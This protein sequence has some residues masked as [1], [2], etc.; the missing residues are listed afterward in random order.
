MN[1]TIKR[2]LNNQQQQMTTTAA[3]VVVSDPELFPS[4]NTKQS[5]F[6]YYSSSKEEEKVVHKYIPVTTPVV[7]G[8]SIERGQRAAVVGL[9]IKQE[10]LNRPQG[11]QKNERPSVSSV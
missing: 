6:K 8:N 7:V 5:F 11:Q 10:H 9:R 2:G 4:I 1:Q 3:E